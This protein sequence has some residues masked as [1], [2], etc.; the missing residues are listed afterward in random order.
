MAPKKN[1]NALSNVI[2]LAPSKVSP[3]QMKLTFSAEEVGSIKELILVETVNIY[4]SPG[5]LVVY[6]G[7]KGGFHVGLFMKKDGSKAILSKQGYFNRRNENLPLQQGDTCLFSR[8]YRRREFTEDY[9]ELKKQLME[10]I[11]RD[12]HKKYL[13]D[14][15]ALFPEE[16]KLVKDADVALGKPIAVYLHD[17]ILIGYYMGLVVVDE[18]ESDRVKVEFS[19]GDDKS[20]I[21]SGHHVNLDSAF[22]Y[23]PSLS[24]KPV[25]FVYEPPANPPTPT[26]PTAPARLEEE[27]E[28]T[29]FVSFLL[30]CLPDTLRG[31]VLSI[32]N[33]IDPAFR[34]VALFKQLPLSGPASLSALLRLHPSAEWNAVF[35]KL[36]YDN[37]HGPEAT[38]ARRRPVSNSVAARPSSVVARASSVAARPSSVATRGDFKWDVLEEGWRFKRMHNHRRVVTFRRATIYRIYAKLMLELVGDGFRK[39]VPDSI[40][41]AAAPLIKEELEFLFKGIPEDQSSKRWFRNASQALNFPQFPGNAEEKQHMEN[42]VLWCTDYIEEFRENPHGDDEEG[43]ED[44]VEEEE[45]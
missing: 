32:V 14:D 12:P 26:P 6:E 16:F 9:D 28:P 37:I 42:A 39:Q 43:S 40:H 17:A 22:V 1:L 13:V 41:T 19:I 25:A 15:P 10:P 35:V 44:D 27:E 3:E 11:I 8:L 7:D 34:C 30:K 36:V 23:I 18:T 21:W 29:E 24:V 38:P 4:P 20:L 5:D 33:E 45:E 2:T 31:N